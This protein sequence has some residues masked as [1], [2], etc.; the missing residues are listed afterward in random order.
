[1]EKSPRAL[2]SS[3]TRKSFMYKKYQCRFYNACLDHAVNADWEQFGCDSCRAFQ[4][5]DSFQKAWDIECLF[6]IQFAADHAAEH[7]F[8]GRKRGVKPGADAKVRRRHLPVVPD[9]H[10]SSMTPSLTS[11][12]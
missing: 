5:V 2:S 10:Q 8:A 12:A 9:S 3:E 7:G 11:A 4:E 1:M 6:A